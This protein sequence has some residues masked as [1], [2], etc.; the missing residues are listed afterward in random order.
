MFSIFSY[1]MSRVTHSEPG[2]PMSRCADNRFIS[3]LV[4][5]GDI[6]DNSQ[7]AKQMKDLR[8]KYEIAL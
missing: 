2:L 8:L 6:I 3:E 4:A 1:I 5:N 7:T